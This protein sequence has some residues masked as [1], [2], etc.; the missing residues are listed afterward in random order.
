MSYG[1][2]VATQKIAGKDSGRNAIVQ[3]LRKYFDHRVLARNRNPV[4]TDEALIIKALKSYFKGD[5]W[6]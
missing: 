1:D 3:V 2:K 5:A 4:R 6:S